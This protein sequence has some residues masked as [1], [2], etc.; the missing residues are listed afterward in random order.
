M[1]AVPVVPQQHQLFR[2]SILAGPVE[3]LDRSP[4][5]L[6][7]SFTVA[8]DEPVLAGHFPGFAILPGVCL[9]EF[10]HHAALLALSDD[11]SD[12]GFDDASEPPVLAA[13]ESARF[14]AAVFPG[15]EVLAEVTTVADGP[16]RR[17]PVRLTVRRADGTERE[18][19]LL[20]LRYRPGE[21][22]GAGR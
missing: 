10:A 13:V 22:P 4:G 20:R 16:V 11:G 3:V 21:P 17:C 19:A 7:A 9:V 15:D 8:P 2:A 5:R 1:S 12:D 18:A 14:R 6:V